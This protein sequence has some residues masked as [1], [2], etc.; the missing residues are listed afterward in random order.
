MISVCVCLAVPVPYGEENEDFIEVIG[1]DNQVHRVNLNENVDVDLSSDTRRNPGNRYF[2]FTRSVYRITLY[3]LQT[4]DNVL[5][6][7]EACPKQ[8]L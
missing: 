8:V 1:E 7:F 2:L 3:G 4:N 6:Y 5:I